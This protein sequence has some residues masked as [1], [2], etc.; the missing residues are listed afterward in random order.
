MSNRRKIG[1]LIF[2][3]A[4]VIIAFTA[5]KA[6]F[7]SPGSEDEGLPLASATLGA[8]T[9]GANEVVANESHSKPETLEIPSIGIKAD[10]QHLGVTSSG[11]MAVPSNYTDTGWYK[12]GPMPGQMGSSVIAG[13][14]DNGLGTPAIFYD[15]EDL[16]IGDSVFVT[17][18]DGE[19]L[20][21]KVKRMETVPYNLK[22]DKLEEIFGAGGGRYL[23]LITCAGDW[24]P[25][26]KTNDL[27]LIVYTELVT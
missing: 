17:R 20:E 21:F 14:Q 26:A 24:L 12:Y 19:R 9:L 10:V 6:L 11:L 22:G 3:A 2:L 5:T 23:N 13:H 18:E 8:D 16:E 1:I 7:W 15:L 4:V 27:R 25:S